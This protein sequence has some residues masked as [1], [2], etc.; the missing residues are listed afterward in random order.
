M[1]VRGCGESWETGVRYS[2]PAD[3]SFAAGASRRMRHRSPSR[4]ASPAPA[5][6]LDSENVRQYAP[7]LARKLK[8]IVA[9]R[10]GGRS[11]ASSVDKAL[12]KDPPATTLPSDEVFNSSSGP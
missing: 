8:P 9:T 6:P 5:W 7:D 3:P 4:Q 12:A 1:M 10:S 2:V 11:A